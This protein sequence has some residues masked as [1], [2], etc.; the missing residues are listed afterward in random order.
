MEKNF[1]KYPFEDLVEMEFPL[2]NIQE[3]FEF[4]N[5]HKPVRVGIFLGSNNFKIANQ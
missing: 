1:R 5:A 4:A 3:A 2:N